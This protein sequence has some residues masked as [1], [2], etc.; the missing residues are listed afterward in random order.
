M[1]LINVHDLKMVPPK[2]IHIVHIFVL[3]NENN[4]EC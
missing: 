3:E 2:F 1:T 4:H